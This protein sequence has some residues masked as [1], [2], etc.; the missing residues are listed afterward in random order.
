MVKNEIRLNW[1]QTIK[2]A[3]LRVSRRIDRA[4]LTESGVAPPASLYIQYGGGNFFDAG[5]EFFKILLD[6][7]NLQ[8]TSSILDVGCG[9]GRMAAPL[10]F[11]LSSQGSYL[12][13]D[14]MPEGIEWCTRKVTPRRPN[15]VFLKADIYNSF[16]NPSGKQRPENY[17]FP[18]N[19]QTCDI[20]LSTSVMTH[21]LPDAMRRYVAET[22]RVLKP[23]GVSLHT[24]YLVDDFAENCIA[25]G[26]SRYPFREAAGYMTSDPSAPEQA[27]ALRDATVEAAYDAAGL[28]AHIRRGSWCGRDGLSYQDIVIGRR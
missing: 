8:R 4:C 24:F 20:V 6:E 27:I 16:Y 10:E 5:L 13:F 23:G 1:K 17:R 22:A 3:M 28:S 18:C 11:F 9:V 15:F 7:C 2:L 19:D 12:G 26:E 14:I 21:L 25:R